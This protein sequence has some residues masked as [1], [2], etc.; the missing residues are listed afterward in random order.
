VLADERPE[1]LGWYAITIRVFLGPDPRQIQNHQPRPVPST[2]VSCTSAEI[3]FIAIIAHPPY[4]LVSIRS[5]ILCATTLLVSIPT[6]N[7]LLKRQELGTIRQSTCVSQPQIISTL[8]SGQRLFIEVIFFVA[9]GNAQAVKVFHYKA[10]Q[11]GWF[12]PWGMAVLAVVP[13]FG[14]GA[15]YLPEG[16]TLRLG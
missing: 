7:N 13:K 2:P 14:Q 15:R 5:F 16:R 8:K 10:N 12:L 6:P 1:L 11:V 3:V 4:W 9:R